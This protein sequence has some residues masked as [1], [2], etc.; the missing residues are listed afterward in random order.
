MRITSK[1]V[2]VSLLFFFPA[3]AS[4]HVGHDSGA[5]HTLSF[6]E[7]FLHPLTGADHLIVMLLVGIWSAINTRQW[8]L[9][10]LVF[11]A[12]LLVGAMIGMAGFVPGGTELMV[13]ASLL[14]LGVMVALQWKLSALTGALVVGG[15]AIFHGLAH[16]AELSHSVAALSGMVIATAGLHIVGLGIGW[17]MLRSSLQQRW[18]RMV[19][20]C[21]TLAGVGL[22]SGLI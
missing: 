15:F 6:M 19:G 14:G 16:G 9:A 7:G 1:S 21:A 3:L 13:A 17:L 4:A 12:L 2:V 20:G 11:A 22:L 5:H 10:P 18:A 8:W